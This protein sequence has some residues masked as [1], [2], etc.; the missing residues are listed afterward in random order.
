RRRQYPRPHVRQFHWLLAAR[1]ASGRA[2][3]FQ[4]ETGRCGHVGGIVPGTDSH[5]DRA[6]GGVESGDQT[7]AGGECGRGDGPDGSIKVKRR[8]R[9]PAFWLC[10]Y[11]ELE[12][13]VE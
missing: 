4:T 8:A 10:T 12:A 13:H 2:A 1:P 6:A 7:N 11:A 5:W 9:R 3:L